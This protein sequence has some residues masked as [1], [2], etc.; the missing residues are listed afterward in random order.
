[1]SHLLP[2]AGIEN[3]NVFDTVL[4]MRDHA[5]SQVSAAVLK[6]KDFD[7][8]FLVVISGIL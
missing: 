2:T 7:W 5:I 1:M 8:A 4:I 6:V 3:W